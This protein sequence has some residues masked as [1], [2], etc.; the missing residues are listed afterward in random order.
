MT[1]RRRRPVSSSSMARDSI[2]RIDPASDLVISTMT[3]GDPGAA[4]PI[5]IAIGDDGDLWVA[6]QK[7][8]ASN[9][10]IAGDVVRVDPGSGQVRATVAVGRNPADIAVC[11][12]SVWITNFL[13]TTITRIDPATGTATPI[14][15]RV[16]G[17][18]ALACG[19]PARCG[20]ATS[21][22]AP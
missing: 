14:D 19:G 1:S 7:W 18:T 21:G 13:D 9:A 8:D 12:G 5:A 3:L 11:A 10:P 17:A 6:R 15:L 20:S 16:P 22:S 2:S 4:L